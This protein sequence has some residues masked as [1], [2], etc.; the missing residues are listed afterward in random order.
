MTND[1]DEYQ[2]YEAS[3]IIKRDWLK[4]LYEKVK[5]KNVP[6]T[7]YDVAVAAG[8]F[9]YELSESFR[10]L[11]RDKSLDGMFLAMTISLPTVTELL[12]IIPKGDPLLIY[13]IIQA[14]RDSMTR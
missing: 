8:E 5:A 13:Y 10:P 7:K 4:K 2:R 3:Q 9:P 1:T 14:A 11:L 6:V 12:N